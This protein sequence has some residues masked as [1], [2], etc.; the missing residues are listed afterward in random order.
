MKFC[1]HLLIL[2]AIV[3]AG[4]SPA[5]AF[6]GAQKGWI[7]ICASDGSVKRIQVSSDYLPD[8]KD[9]APAEQSSLMEDCLFCF[10]TAQGKAASSPSFLV[11][12]SLT[13]GYIAVG[14]GTYIP[15]NLQSAPF[16][17]R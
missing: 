14:S 16:A 4:I 17:P 11:M 2:F 8:E 1:I 9:S 13:S 5:C 12:T 7:E 15:R 6:M 3:T 10:A